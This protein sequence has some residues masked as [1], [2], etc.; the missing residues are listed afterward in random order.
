MQQGDAAAAST[1]AQAAGASSSNQA[2]S[3]I[4]TESQLYTLRNQILAFRNI[5][6]CYL[7]PVPAHL[8]RKSADNSLHGSR[9]MP[10]GCVWLALDDQFC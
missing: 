3:N 9:V 2:T 8:L 1:P 7:K 6:V 4:F 5:K 10:N